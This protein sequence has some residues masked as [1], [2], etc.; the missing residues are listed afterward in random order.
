[1]SQNLETGRNGEDAAC[2]YLESKGFMILD[3]NYRFEGAEV[4]IICFEPAERY[5][6]GG[7][8]VFVEVKTRKSAS[9]APLEESISD[10]QKKS[11]MRGAE[12]YLH[13]RRLDG[14]PCRFDVIGVR[15]SGTNKP[16]IDH[17]RDAFWAFGPF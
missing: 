10:A 4:D 5:E 7:E 17:L 12:A 16:E 8:L 9:A 6:A 15:L 2:E 1:V 11:L 3:R 14:S 13:E